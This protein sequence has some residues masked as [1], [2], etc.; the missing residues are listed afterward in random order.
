MNPSSPRGSP[1]RSSRLSAVGGL[2][3]PKLLIVKVQW[4]PMSVS[5]WRRKGGAGG[6]RRKQGACTGIKGQ[7]RGGRGAL[8]VRSK[9]SEVLDWVLS[10][11]PSVNPN[12]L[13]RCDYLFSFNG[14]HTAAIC[15]MNLGVASP[16]R[17]CEQSVF[18]INKA[19][20]AQETPDEPAHQPRPWLAPLLRLVP[21]HDA[22][23]LVV[24]PG[25]VEDVHEALALTAYLLPLA[26][27]G[28]VRW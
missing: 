19:L 6:G 1:A 24:L 28:P 17:M 10:S 14:V 2:K 4:V 26:P 23:I 9:R 22:Q 5:F 15:G 3:Q 25:R 8:E 16:A 27:P 21:P 11:G 12:P 20:L 18:K 13:C 7:R